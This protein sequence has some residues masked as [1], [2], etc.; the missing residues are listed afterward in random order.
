MR[1]RWSKQC[2]VVMIACICATAAACGQQP[3]KDSLW[4]LAEEAYQAGQFETGHN[5]LTNLVNLS[6]GD[7]NRAISCLEEILRQAKRQDANRLAQQKRLT[8]TVPK[9]LATVMCS[10]SLSSW[11]RKKTRP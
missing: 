8:F 1:P 6:S 7:V 5:Y 3:H 11:S 2:W 4:K 10:S 9:R